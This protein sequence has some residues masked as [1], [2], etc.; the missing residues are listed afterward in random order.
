[1]SV[2]VARDTH[3]ELEYVDASLNGPRRN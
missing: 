2:G 1:M 3:K